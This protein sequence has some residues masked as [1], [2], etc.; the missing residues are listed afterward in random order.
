MRTLATALGRLEA[1][2]GRFAVLGNHDWCDDPDAQTSGHGPVIAEQELTAADVIVLENRAVCSVAQRPSLLDCG[3]GRSAGQT[4]TP[5]HR[6]DDLHALT[7]QI[8][9]NEPA[10]LLAHEPDIFPAAGHRFAVTLP[11]HTHAGQIKIAGRTPVV[12]SRFGSR[13]VSV[14]WSRTGGISSSRPDSAPAWCR[15][16]SAPDQRSSSSSSADRR[17]NDDR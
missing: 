13:Y 1:R 17:Q 10:L 15:S 14:T 9:A 12:P 2:L 7:G 11:G 16:V 3:L 5:D 8:P 6:I 4:R